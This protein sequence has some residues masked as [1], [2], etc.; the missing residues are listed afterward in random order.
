MQILNERYNASYNALRA[1]KE[2]EHQKLAMYLKAQHM[3]IQDLMPASKPET[4]LLPS[5]QQAVPLLL[6]A[7][8]LLGPDPARSCSWTTQLLETPWSQA[9]EAQDYH[10]GMAARVLL[11]V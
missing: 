11:L 3:E 6:L 2:V 10:E 9:E 4:S 1:A 5:S 8:P 7:E